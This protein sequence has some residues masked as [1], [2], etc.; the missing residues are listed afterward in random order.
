LN[1]PEIESDK[2]PGE[3][4]RLKAR[5]AELERLLARREPAASG[6]GASAGAADARAREEER[7]RTEEALQKTTRDL[8]TLIQ[9]SPLAFIALDGEGN[10]TSWNLAAERIFGWSREEV[11]GH[12]IPY[13]PEGGQGESDVLWE[14]VMGGQ[15][16]RGV[17][18]RRRR[19]D[20]TIID[21]H[22]WAAPLRDA[23]G[24]VIST[25]GLLDD[26]T[27]RKRLEEQLRQSQ[28]MEAV[29]RLA[30]GVAHD[31]N[32]LLTVIIGHSQRLLRHLPAGDRFRKSVEG[33]KQA[34]ERAA[35]LTRQLLA[36]G[37]KQIIQPRLM[38]LNAVVTNIVE[39]LR[40]LIGED[41]HLAT[42][43]D[44]AP[45]LIKA[46][47]GQ[48]E[49]VLM[50]LAVNARD[51]MP[52]GG[53]LTIT[54]ATVQGAD[55][56]AIREVG[57]P[58]GAYVQLT[59]S[60]TGLGI[61]QESLAHIFEPFYTT[62]E[63]GKGTGLG[64][65]TVYGI[66][67]QSGGTIGVDSLPGQGT[68]FSIFLPQA[69]G[70]LPAPVEVP[71]SVPEADHTET[72]LLVREFLRDHLVGQGYQVVEAGNGAQ[73][74]RVCE[75]CPDALHL[76][77]TDVVITDMSG[78]ILAE[79]ATALRPKMKVLFMSGYTDDIVLRHG[80]SEATAE[81]LQKP[82]LP[83]TLSRKIRGM[84]DVS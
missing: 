36:F 39:M 3:L 65:A 44:P 42:R 18:I 11:L 48:I 80:I 75:T 64:L 79:R 19:K 38:D 53:M 52:G 1:K 30:G 16:L 72:I 6:P 60:D 68:T 67:I 31:F 78:R 61:D 82:F 34:G 14:A 43:L 54:T 33:I 12:P 4:D 57:L 56:A 41:I 24:R 81:F 73:A 76:L 66:V 37:H 28:K 83:E 2:E 70:S 77:L 17:E 15:F 47:P 7:R 22:L 13:V 29:G 32:N 8:Q 71:E 23:T 84:L 35:S 46:D 26:I 74:L 59:V 10:V 50:N 55:L 49:Q 25:I 21:L 69:A 45:C 58:V 5:V 20:G 63:R 9:A 51:A 27:E 62:K 40:R